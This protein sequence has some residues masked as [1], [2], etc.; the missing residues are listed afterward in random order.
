MA[1]RHRAFDQ[2]CR[3]RSE[4]SAESHWKH[5]GH[6][7]ELACQGIALH[8]LLGVKERPYQVA[9]GM[10]YRHDQLPGAA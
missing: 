9:V 6:P 10:A 2:L 1:L 8:E 7:A 4:A 5:H 3:K